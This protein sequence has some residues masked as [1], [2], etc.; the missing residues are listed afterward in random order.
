M[1]KHLT[2]IIQTLYIA[3]LGIWNLKMLFF[4]PYKLK[5]GYF[6]TMSCMAEFVVVSGIIFSLAAPKYK[7]IIFL[8]NFHELQLLKNNTVSNKS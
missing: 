1:A 5:N 7:L 2:P 6:G 8:D 3:C 4:R